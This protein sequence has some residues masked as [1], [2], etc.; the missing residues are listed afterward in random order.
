LRLD[1]AR[2]S[3]V[4]RQPL[5]NER[6]STLCLEFTSRLEENS[7]QPVDT[8]AQGG[9]FQDRAVDGLSAQLCAQD[10]RIEIYHPLAKALWCDRLAVVRN[11]GWQQRHRSAYRDSLAAIEVVP[12][13]PVVNNQ[14]GPLVMRVHW[15][16]V[17]GELRVEY[18]YDSL[19][20]R[21]PRLEL[22]TGEHA[23]IV[24]DMHRRG[25]R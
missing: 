16:L 13:S 24:Q 2:P 22:L 14:Q 1:L 11:V 20:G 4:F 21:P 3:Q 7:M 19:Q 18:F 10:R 17:A 15:V 12:D 9:V 6:E 25:S 8:L 23:R 5:D